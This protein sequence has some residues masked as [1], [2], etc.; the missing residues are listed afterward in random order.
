M[1][2]SN[3]FSLLAEALSPMFMQAY[4]VL[5]VA[6]V[7]AGVLFDMRH[8][9]SAEFFARRRESARAAAQR[10]LGAAAIATIAVETLVVDVMA[11][12]EFDKWPRRL[13]HLLTAYGFVIYLVT[14]VVMVFGY[15]SDPETPWAWTALWHLGALM[16]LAGGSWFFFA[17]RADVAQEARAPLR[18][19]QADIFIVGLLA[20]SAFA[21]VWHAAQM[22]DNGAG[23]TMVLFGL[24]LFSTTLLFVTVPWSKFAHMFY[25]PAAA[26]Q[27]R[28]EA[29]SGASDLPRPAEISHIRR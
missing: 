10:E 25:K 13:S 21:L 14:T 22:L 6:A 20:S 27:K 4:V 5:M 8:K 29:A 15:A 1:F 16:V 17:L 3:P 26:F 28:L 11:A 23:V 9:R 7:V 19:R 2:V 18:L 12:G 24:Y